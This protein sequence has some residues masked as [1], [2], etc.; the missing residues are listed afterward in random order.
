V[1]AMV[2]QT[3]CLDSSLVVVRTTTENSRVIHIGKAVAFLDFQWRIQGGCIGCIC[4]P[5]FESYYHSNFIK[6]LLQKLVI[7]H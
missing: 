4:N 7:L 6:Q 3:Q 1:F 5:L 2:K